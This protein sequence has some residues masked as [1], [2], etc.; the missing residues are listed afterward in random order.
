LNSDYFSE[1][2]INDLLE[3]LR[4][5]TL[6][7]EEIIKFIVTVV[8]EKE[9][10]TLKSVTTTTQVTRKEIKQKSINLSEWP[11]EDQLQKAL[12]AI[13]YEVSR[14]QTEGEKQ[15]SVSIWGFLQSEKLPDDKSKELLQRCK[16]T[17]QEVLI[18]CI[19][20]IQRS[21]EGQF[22][23][24]T[25]SVDEQTQKLLQNITQISVG[26]FKGQKI[27]LWNLLL[28]KYISSKKR[29]I[30]GIS[31]LVFFYP[32]YYKNDHHHYRGD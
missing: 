19:K 21:G 31:Y 9:T 6:T 3:K 1:S 26:E 28:A 4:A 14:Q 17:V 13:P 18:G 30:N 32:R 15:D 12:E 29:K 11:P 10:K 22:S 20:L 23:A 7:L 8:T 27:S 24:E 25:S 5:G 16:N 2:E